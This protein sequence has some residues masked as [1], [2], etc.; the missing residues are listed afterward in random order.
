MGFHRRQAN[1]NWWHAWNNC[2]CLIWCIHQY[3]KMLILSFAFVLPIQ[4]ISNTNIETKK[5]EIQMNMQVLILINR[6]F[7][8][9]IFFCL[10]LAAANANT[11]TEYKYGTQIQN[12]NTEYKYRIQI[13]NTNTKKQIPNTNTEYKY[14]IQNTNTVLVLIDRLLA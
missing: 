9:P 8:C 11:N 2:I 1:L 4:L 6:L 3:I 12:T 13:Q 14:R 5:K 10:C 7:G